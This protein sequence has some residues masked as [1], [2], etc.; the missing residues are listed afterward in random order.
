MPTQPLWI[1]RLPELITKLQ[2]REAPLWWDRPAIE[3]LF[4]LRRRQVIDLLRRLGARRIG[5]GFALERDA[6]LRFLQDP[7][8]RDAYDDER[9]RRER[10]ESGLGQARRERDRRAISIPVASAPER[11]DFAGLPAGIELRRHQLT[12]SFQ[13]P[14]ELLEK[15]FALGQALR[16]DYETFEE[17]MRA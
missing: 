12:I 10:V 11:I 15:L 3:T 6:L 1:E 14:G 9:L 17:R 7:K 5:T 13:Q 16:N 4:G 2:E 8:R